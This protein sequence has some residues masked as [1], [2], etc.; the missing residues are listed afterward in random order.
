MSTED[1]KVIEIIECAGD[2]SA[3]DLLLLKRYGVKKGFHFETASGRRNTSQ[4][5]LRFKAYELILL[6]N[7][8]RRKGL[9]RSSKLRAALALFERKDATGSSI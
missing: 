3:E 8:L 9:A 2:P 7:P 4:K 6:P 5:D 1:E